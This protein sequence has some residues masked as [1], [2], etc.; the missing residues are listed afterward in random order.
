MQS[1]IFG[2]HPIQS[3]RVGRGRFAGDTKPLLAGFIGNE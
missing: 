2:I 3:E 1:E